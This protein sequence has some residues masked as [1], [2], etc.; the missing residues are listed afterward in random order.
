MYL[1]WYANDFIVPAIGTFREEE[2]VGVK[3]PFVRS[4]YA[5]DSNCQSSTIQSFTFIRLLFIIVSRKQ[6][7]NRDFKDSKLLKIEFIWGL[8]DCEIIALLRPTICKPVVFVLVTHSNTVWTLICQSTYLLVNASSIM[9]QYT[10]EF[11]KIFETDFA[12]EFLLLKVQTSPF[13][14]YELIIFS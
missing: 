12:L 6:L 11:V 7:W 1:Y 4:Y 3:L 5:D 14:K 10:K 9:V 2:T 13:L 8:E